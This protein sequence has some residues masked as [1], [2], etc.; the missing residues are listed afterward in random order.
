M[1]ATNALQ[2][3][4]FIQGNDQFANLLSDLWFINCKNSYRD[5]YFEPGIVWNSLYGV[6]AEVTDRKSKR[7]NLQT[8]STYFCILESVTDTYGSFSNKIKT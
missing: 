6:P 7:K 3:I 8:D 2:G 5:V 4:K 1:V